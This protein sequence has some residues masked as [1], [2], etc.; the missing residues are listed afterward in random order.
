MPKATKIVIHFD[1]GTTHEIQ[2]SK[3][4]SLFTSEARA[5]LCG[6]NPPYG[7]PAGNP[8]SVTTMDSADCYYVNGVIYCP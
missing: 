1:D 4:G 7:T 5:K 3:M 8:N 2:A 6:H